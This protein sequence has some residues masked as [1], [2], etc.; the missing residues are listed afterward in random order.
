MQAIRTGINWAKRKVGRNNPERLWLHY[1]FALTLIMAL[2]LSTHF[3]NK[4]IIDH[5]ATAEIA[6]SVA[7]AQI[8]ATDAILARAGE[9]ASTGDIPSA[10]LEAAIADFL[11]INRSLQDQSL[12]S[13]ELERHF[14][15]GVPGLNKQVE[16]FVSL[17]NKLSTLP[18]ESRAPVMGEIRRLHA[19]SGLTEMQQETLRLLEAG[20]AMRARSLA[21]LQ[22]AILIISALVLLAEAL[23]IFLPAQLTVQSSIAKLRNQA[24]AMRRSK[25]K[26]AEMNRQLEYLLSHD[27]LTGLPN[28]GSVVKYLRDTLN[29]HPDAGIGIV[30]VGLDNFKTLNDTAGHDFGDGVLCAVAKAFE[31]CIDSEDIVARNGGDEFV[32]VTFESP[33]TLANRLMTSLTEPFSVM[34]RKI[35]VSASIGYLTADS[36]DAD[37]LSLIANAGIAM[38]TAKDAGRNRAQEFTPC[39][40]DRIETLQTLQ[41]ELPDAIA[42]GQIEPWFQPQ[43]RLSNGKIHGAEVLARWRHPTR[44]LL[45]PDKF[46]PAAVKAGLMIELD[47]AIWRS[48]M[49]SVMQW[50]MAGIRLPHISL[51][52][53][54]ETISDPNLMERFLLLL[55]LSG[56]GAD[57]II[58]EVLETTIIN[59][60][61]DMAAINI[62]SLAECGI[63]LELD[64]FGTGY[65][66][67]SRLTQLPLAGIKLDRSLVTSLPDTAADSVIRAIL[68]L[69]AEL[70][71]QVVA[72]GIEEDDQAIS[73]CAHG[74]AVGQGYG[75]ARPMSADR[76]LSWLKGNPTIT[77]GGN[78]DVIPLIKRA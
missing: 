52:A 15:E 13:P 11:R 36:P 41:L 17:A 68:A 57:Q 4:M 29:T 26:L 55:H 8:I 3:V 30:F 56:L 18:P 73:L 28:R 27:P 20:A 35:S 10:G 2:F 63:S 21:D 61:D 49:A 46:L 67:L 19:M 32:L 53:A 72:E 50:Q 37:A 22:E 25:K 75:F 16:R 9:F 24:A 59:G 51:N 34:G 70:G 5:G 58:V 78:S 40:R 31:G 6:R 47:H 60:T 23:F 74:C 1:T 45:S 39:L 44:G 33:Q 71:L 69:A 76:F 43:I 14:L 77:Q 12:W 38:Q 65:A 42:K 7:N 64:D 48:A 62:D 66:S 54:P